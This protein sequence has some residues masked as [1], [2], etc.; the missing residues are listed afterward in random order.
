MLSRSGQ[1]GPGGKLVK[2]LDIPV[3][4]ELEEGVIALAAVAG[5]PKAE[6]AR[7]VLE[8][9]VFGE[10]PMLRRMARPGGSRQWD[11]SRTQAD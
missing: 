9:C 4:E 11:E 10:L 7:Q 1:T 3:S 5:L 8:R 6:F 2:R